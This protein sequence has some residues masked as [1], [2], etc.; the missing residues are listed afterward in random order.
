MSNL[1]TALIIEGG[2]NRGVFSFG[3]IDQFISNNFDPFDL[4]LG[5]S[6]GAVAL[7]WY[8]IRETSNNLEK[9]LFGAN[10]KYVNYMNIFKGKTIV[11]FDLLYKEGA[12]EFDLNLNQLSK[13][14]GDK[15][16]FLAA[17]E[18]LTATAN[19]LEF[20]KIDWFDKMI[21]TGTLPV[22]VKAPTILNG[23]RYFDGGI[24]DPIPVKKAYELGAKRIIIIRTYEQSFIRKNKLENYLGAAL[25]Y[26]YPNLSRALLNHSKTYND[27]LKFIANPPSDCE[28]V[29][30]CPPNRLRVKRDTMD[31]SLLSSDYQV[32][33]DSGKKFLNEKS[34]LF[35]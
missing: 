23:K 34:T 18:A 12:V 21:A 32:G 29:Q 5:V 28:I 3:V 11:D 25:M 35:V 9:M 16:I 6:N 33:I 31:K 8:L 7:T 19:Y 27:C 10:K 2:G 13:N 24:A 4:Y 15:K 22:L 30:I 26:K 1:K 17:T 20:N 14:L